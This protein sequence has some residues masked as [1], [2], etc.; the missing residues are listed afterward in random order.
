MGFIA[1]LV[2][3][4]AI[5]A[6][7]VWAYAT[8]VLSPQAKVAETTQT[9]GASQQS[10]QTVKPDTSD[11]SLNADLQAFDSQVQC[12]QKASSDVDTSFND[13]PVSQTE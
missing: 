9:Q 3:G 2:L 8:F 11:A 13:K 10:A 6:A 7:L 4:L 1:K 5:I 12:T